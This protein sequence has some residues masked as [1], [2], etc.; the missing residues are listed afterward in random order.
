MIE[1]GDLFTDP[2][3]GETR[4]VASKGMLIMGTNGKLPH[5]DDSVFTTDGGCAGAEEVFD[6][7]IL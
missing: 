2:L 4:R 3:D 1:V 5:W 6:N 7:L